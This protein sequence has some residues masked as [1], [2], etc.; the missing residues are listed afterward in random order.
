M[1]VRLLGITCVLIAMLLEAF[2][3]LA[4]KRGADSALTE[5][6]GLAQVARLWRHR[7]VIFG[8]AC[9][10]VE[11]VLWTMALRLLDVSV[12]YPAGSLCF[13][14]VTLLAQFYLHEQVNRQRW[15]GV[16]LILGGVMLIGMS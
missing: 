14:F 16:G 4:L 2:G 9:F 3:Q 5:G 11:A 13:V 6:G 12:A 1:S 15:I 7:I 8:I 10:V